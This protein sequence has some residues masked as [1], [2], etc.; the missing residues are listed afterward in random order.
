MRI[1][2]LMALATILT[3]APATA[4]EAWREV[5]PPAEFLA[6]AASQSDNQ[7][8]KELDGLR[9]SA[10]VVRQK[11]DKKLTGRLI[12]TSA[13]ALVVTL[14]RGPQTLL[15]DQICEITVRSRDRSKSIGWIAGLTL[16][17][18]VLGI[19]NAHV[20]ERAPSPA[21]TAAIG[22]GFGALIGAL[23][24]GHTIYSVSSC[25]HR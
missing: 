9:G 11:S 5:E 23:P 10:I 16:A 25:G 15:R 24:S 12:S 22:G 17:G 2:L 1:L 3:A 6:L 20:N 21:L 7:A 14:K 19:V 13:D 18:L 8:W 4:C